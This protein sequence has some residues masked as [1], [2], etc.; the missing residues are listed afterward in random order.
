MQN[1]LTSKKY[2][3]EAHEKK[4]GGKGDPQPR[5]QFPICRVASKRYVRFGAESGSECRDDWFL[6]DLDGDKE[7]EEEEKEAEGHPRLPAA[8][9]AQPEREIWRK[10][11]ND[12]GRDE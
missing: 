1:I 10:R 8:G 7:Q 3:L 12:K 4:K 9:A 2:H 5:P 6:R 11:E